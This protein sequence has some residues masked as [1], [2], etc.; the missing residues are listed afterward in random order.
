MCRRKPGRRCPKHC[1]AEL[2]AARAALSRLEESGADTTTARRDV[3]AK[4]ADLDS[5]RAARDANA[6]GLAELAL[7]NQTPTIRARR[8]EL[9][10]HLAVGETLAA[11]RERQ[12]AL[13][14][15]HR[16]NQPEDAAA[17]HAEIGG[18]RDDIARFHTLTEHAHAAGDTDNAAHWAQQRD[19]AAAAALDAE[20]RWRIRDHQ[21]EP[22]AA[23]LTKQETAHAR[24]RDSRARELLY[25]SHKR[26]A[27]NDLPGGFDT[28]TRTFPP[29]DPPDTGSNGD[30]DNTTT[31]DPQKKWAEQDT[32][33][34]THD[35]RVLNRL[36]KRGTRLRSARRIFTNS[37]RQAARS[38]VEL[39]SLISPNG[40]GGGRR[41]G[42]TSDDVTSMTGL[43]LLTMLFEEDTYS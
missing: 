25:E 38:T 26:A 30:T 28:P 22:A 20:T 21:G 17:L 41:E 3:A 42:L 27:L 40:P 43:G 36:T 24:G 18:Q 6:A 2:A 39:A 7:A 8:R 5:T 34:A 31:T 37:R 33:R 4:S 19:N 12:R 23:Y 9:A 13:M 16:K 11:E 35:Q 15:P 10:E 29:L 14:P 32:R 1:T